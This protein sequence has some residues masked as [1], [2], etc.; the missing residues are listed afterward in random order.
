MD[1]VE[2]ILF[3]KRH[4]FLK[5]PQVHHGGRRVMGKAEDQDLRPRQ[6]LAEG[7]EHIFKE[8]A[9]PPQRE[10]AHL[11][12]GNDDA[13]GMN[14]IARSRREDDIARSHHRQRKVRQALLRSHR[15]DGFR[16]RIQIHAIIALIPRANRMAELGDSP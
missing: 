5:K 1:H 8:V 11:T 10:S 9:I 7:G 3:R 14:G 4:N 12:A 13:V 2:I 15:D 6:G 16:L